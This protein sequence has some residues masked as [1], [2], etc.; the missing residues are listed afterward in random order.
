MTSLPALA[1]LY[2]WVDQNGKVHYSDTL[3]PEAVDRPRAKLR[4]DG[5]VVE[6]IERGLSPEERRAQAARAEQEAKERAAQE[7][8]ARLDQALLDRYTS[9]EEFDRFRE[10]SIQN[11]DDELRALAAREP[12]LTAK[13]RSLLAGQGPKPGS[14]AMN[15]LRN[16]QIE[17]QA[18]AELIGRRLQAR[19]QQ[20]RALQEE[21]ERL[22]RLLAERAQAKAMETSS[23]KR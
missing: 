23:V 4:Q 18:L 19:E 15:E 13:I 20:V 14:P 6:R 8:R 2:R 1:Q 11:A 16:A 5:I 10:R 9:L 3:P 22:A 12:A 17:A 21:R 7:A